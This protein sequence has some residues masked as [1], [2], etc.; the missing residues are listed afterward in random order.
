[1][2]R[3]TEDRAYPKPRSVASAF[4]AR[5]AAGAITTLMVAVGASI[6]LVCL[7]YAIFAALRD[8]L[9]GA[10]AV[11]FALVI[12]LLAVVGP[13]IIRARAAAVADHDIGGRAKVDSAV[14]ARV[15]R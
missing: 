4:E 10:P 7:A 6:T 3:L 8:W 1:M 5:V 14:C 11:T 9:A 13:K 2:A 12:F 15:S